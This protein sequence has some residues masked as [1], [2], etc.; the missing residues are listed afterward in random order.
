[1]IK[2]LSGN[3]FS[4]KSKPSAYVHEVKT[5]IHDEEDIPQDMQ[6]LVYNGKKLED[7][8]KLE[9]YQMK[10]GTILHLVLALRG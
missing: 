8:K 2:T 4:I 7:G 5:L 9:E 10:D 3:T 6:R 1:M